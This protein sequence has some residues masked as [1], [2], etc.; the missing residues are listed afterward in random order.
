MAKSPLCLWGFHEFI[1]DCVQLNVVSR[2]V[3]E[4]TTP[5]IPGDQV[6]RLQEMVAHHLPSSGSRVSVME[7]KEEELVQAIRDEMRER[8]LTIQA[9]VTEK[10]SRW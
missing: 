9:E 4:V 3:L 10:V 5:L 6:T 8:H 2:A 1:S 7:E